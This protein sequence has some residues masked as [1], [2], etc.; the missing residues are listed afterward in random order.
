ME[1]KK[2]KAVRNSDGEVLG[3]WTDVPRGDGS[4]LDAS[5]YEKRFGEIGSFSI[6][7]EDFKAEMLAAKAKFLAKEA[8]VARAKQLIGKSL[9]ALEIKEAVELILAELFN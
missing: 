8:R 1:I 5:H 9:T 4:V 7:E 2:F 6:V 3:I